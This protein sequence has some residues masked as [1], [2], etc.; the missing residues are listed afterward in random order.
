MHDAHTTDWCNAAASHYL[1]TFGFQNLQNEVKV[2]RAETLGAYE[3]IKRAEKENNIGDLQ[4]VDVDVR[5]GKK[6][7]VVAFVFFFSLLGLRLWKC[8]S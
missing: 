7:P 4:Y 8:G 1:A 3:V 5:D 2:A 6:N